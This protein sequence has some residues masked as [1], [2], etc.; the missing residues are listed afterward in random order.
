MNWYFLR[1]ERHGHFGSRD[2]FQSV[3]LLRE[4]VFAVEILHFVDEFFVSKLLQVLEFLLLQ[5]LVLLT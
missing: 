5:T 1:L 3:V 4:Q 2:G